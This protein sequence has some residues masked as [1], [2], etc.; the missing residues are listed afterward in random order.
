LS[1][2][3]PAT[4]VVH[5]H[6]FA[7]ALSPSIG[8]V[9]TRGRLPHVYTLH[10]Y[11]LACPNGGFYDY[12]KNEICTRRALGASC[13][14]THCD[15]R[16]PSHKAW[17]VLR[18]TIL[19]SA[20][21]LPRGLRDVVYNSETQ[22]RVLQSYFR[23]QARLHYIP[24]PVLIAKKPRVRVE[25]N[26]VFLFVGRLSPEKGGL[27]FAEAAREAA[28]KA[29]LVGDGSERDAIERANPD[30]V[31]T[32]WVSPQEVEA[33]LEKARCLVFPSFWYECQPLVPLEALARGVPVIA[34]AWTA[35][36]E[37]VEDGVTG[38]LLQDL[39]GL[40]EAMSSAQHWVHSASRE[41]NS[42]NA[43]A[44]DSLREHVERLTDLYRGVLAK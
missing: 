18:Q 4:S 11:F 21:N 41:A 37:S 17:R 33:W 5:C 39:S 38:V 34:G 35:A 15:V 32:G 24:N 8:P 22:R 20:G 10:E 1:D 2:F 40:K 29:V 43:A 44:G 27:L 36:A 7:K 6:G 14:T 9:L 25:N 31:V 16:S 3:D 28:L 30:A 12:Q 23:P 26:D 19:W 42:R 13:L